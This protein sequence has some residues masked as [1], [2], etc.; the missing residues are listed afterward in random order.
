MAQRMQSPF[1]LPPLEFYEGA[2]QDE[3]VPPVQKSEITKSG[4]FLM[5]L[6]SMGFAVMIAMW[7][8]PSPIL[9]GIRD[10]IDAFFGMH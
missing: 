4:V 6:V 1:R 2:E 5:V 9:R 7:A 3:P 10:Q 8:T